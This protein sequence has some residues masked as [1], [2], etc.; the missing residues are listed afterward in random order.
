MK[1]KPKMTVRTKIVNFLTKNMLH[2]YSA[3]T[4]AKRL[5]LNY[6]TVRRELGSLK[7]YLNKI[8]DIKDKRIFYSVDHIPV[9]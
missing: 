7:P 4:I 6:N 9:L 3:P 2:Y 5:K 1:I 8:K